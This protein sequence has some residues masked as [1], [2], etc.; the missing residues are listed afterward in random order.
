MISLFRLKTSTTSRGYSVIVL[1][2]YLYGGHMGNIWYWQNRNDI[3]SIFG[4]LPRTLYH[5]RL[6]WLHAMDSHRLQILMPHLLR[7]GDS[8][9]WGSVDV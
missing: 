2:I 5:V 3:V 7:K 9:L 8:G 6:S 4:F 1:R